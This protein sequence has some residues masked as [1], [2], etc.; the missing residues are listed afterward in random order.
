MRNLN[1]IP[2]PMTVDELRELTIL[3]IEGRPRVIR[4]PRSLQAG[5]PECSQTRQEP[6]RMES[7]PWPVPVNLLAE[8]E[9]GRTEWGPSWSRDWEET[10][11]R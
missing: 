11:C 9:T 10:T 3:P 1:W 2:G 7:R 8:E 5:M 4:A 6:G